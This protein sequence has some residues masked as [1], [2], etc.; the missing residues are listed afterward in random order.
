MASLRSLTV[1]DLPWMRTEITVRKLLPQTAQASVEKQGANRLAVRPYEAL[2]LPYT[3]E[4]D[5]Q[6]FGEF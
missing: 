5:A 2:R 3:L 6:R 1:V 4:C